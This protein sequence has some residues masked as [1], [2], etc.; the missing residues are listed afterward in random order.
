[1][2]TAHAYHDGVSDDDRDRWDRRYASLPAVTPEKICLPVVF[3]PFSHLF[4]TAGTAWDLACGRARAAIWLAQRGM[5]VSGYDV[6]PVA[7]AE[8][9]L[10]ARRYGCAARTRFAVADLDD[11]LPP[12]DPVDVVLCLNFRDPRLDEPMQ[13]RVRRGGLL[14]ISALSEVGAGPGRYRVAPGELARAFDAL[15]VLACGEADGQ[16]WLLA[17][18]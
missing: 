11:G 15:D 7:V 16:A 14:A 18:R 4:P 10:L 5:T 17:R 8:A 1:M 12:G 9:R 6:S 13:S 3:Q 2:R